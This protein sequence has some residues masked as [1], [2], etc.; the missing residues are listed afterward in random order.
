MLLLGCRS[1]PRR[2]CVAAALQDHPTTRHAA[3]LGCSP[4]VSLT[5]AEAYGESDPSAM[6]KVARSMAPDVKQGDQV[7]IS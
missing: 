2:K 5:A 7:L 4:Q 3:D 1:A 6:L